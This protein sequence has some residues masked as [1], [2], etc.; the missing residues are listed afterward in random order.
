LVYIAI[1]C[2]TTHLYGYGLKTHVRNA[3]RLGATPEV[4]I[5]AYE[6]AALMGVQ[7][8]LMGVPVLKAALTK[9]GP[10]SQSPA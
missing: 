8:L 9:L 5:E 2:S 7:T 1:D 3:T 10:E 6:L 4:I